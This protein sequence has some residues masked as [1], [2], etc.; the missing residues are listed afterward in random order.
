MKLDL[1]ITAQNL[2]ASILLTQADP[3]SLKD[4]RLGGKEGRRAA[5][6]TLPQSGN[7]CSNDCQRILTKCYEKWGFITSLETLWNSLLSVT[8]V[9]LRGGESSTRSRPREVIANWEEILFRISRIQE[10][11]SY[12][13]TR[14]VTS[15][16]RSS[17]RVNINALTLWKQERA[18]T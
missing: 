4:R 8:E 9:R 10:K 6:K 18:Y 13:A 3:R 1:R 14:R 11:L 17:H 2:L 12:F 16:M 7:N 5:L 15:N